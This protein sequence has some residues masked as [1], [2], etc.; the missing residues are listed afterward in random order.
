LWKPGTEVVLDEFT[1]V[2]NKPSPA[3]EKK[4]LE[5]N[6]PIPPI[7]RKESLILIAC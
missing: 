4:D 1:I 3:A 2:H 6:D 5:N 7:I